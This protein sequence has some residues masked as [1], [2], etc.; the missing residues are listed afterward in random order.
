M[1]ALHFAAAGGNNN[2]IFFLITHGAKVDDV[3]KV[4]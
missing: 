3:N 2:V 1:T 4:S